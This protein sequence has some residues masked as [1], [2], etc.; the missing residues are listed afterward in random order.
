MKKVIKSHEKVTSYTLGYML[1]AMS[2]KGL[3][4]LCNL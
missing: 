3:S 4:L 1:Q 2:Y